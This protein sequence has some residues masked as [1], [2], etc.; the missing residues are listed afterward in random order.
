MIC[1]K[2]KKQIPENSTYCNFCGKKQ[3]VE[4]KRT[5]RRA[6]GQGS[7]YKLSG[8]RKKPFAVFLPATYSET[9][10]RNRE[11]LGCYETK[12]EALNVLNSFISGKISDRVNSTFGQI[13]NEWSE[14]KY[15]TLSDSTVENYKIAF[16]HLQPLENKKMKDVKSPDV[17]KIID[18]IGKAET[19]KK[20]R[21]LYSHLCQYAMS[22]DIILQN[23]SKFLE[24]PQ[25]EKKEKEVFT[26]SEI[27]KIHEAANQG[28]DTAKIVMMMIFTGT[29]IGEIT[30]IKHNEVY[31]DIE[32]PYMIGGIKSEAGKNRI[33]PIHPEI[34]EYTKYFYK[35]NECKKV[36][37]LLTSPKGK[38]INIK[39]FRDR[40]FY[41]LL[42]Q[43]EIDK[44]TPHCT[45]HTYATMLQAA[46]AKSENLIKLIGH[47]DYKTTTENY[48]H[49]S[50]N[51]LYDTVKLLKFD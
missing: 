49:Q 30:T 45:R 14:L 40:E 35:K 28:N 23:Y 34:F 41:P 38:K 33:I 42:E 17:Q 11:L 9:G 1:V 29:R 48:I 5:R 3:T 27:K 18:K 37:L 31:L 39:N 2:C 50:I 47:A 20:I 12:T 22:L 25:T 7:V 44:K 4:K 13:Y 43:L 36:N 6:N 10:R 16:K 32:P 8:T 26:V 15:K 21:Q 51:E 46:G 19:A 24:I